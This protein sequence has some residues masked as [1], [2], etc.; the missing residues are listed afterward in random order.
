MKIL[1]KVLFL[2]HKNGSLWG[3]DT[4]LGNA[5]VEKLSACTHKNPVVFTPLVSSLETRR[6]TSVRLTAFD[7]L[8]AQRLLVGHVPIYRNIKYFLCEIKWAAH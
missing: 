8:I 6:T 1:F 3:E 5:V 4:G 2:G 7:L